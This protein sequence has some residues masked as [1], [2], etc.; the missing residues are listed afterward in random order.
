MIINCALLV[1]RSETHCSHAS[2]YALH[3]LTLGRTRCGRPQTTIWTISKNWRER[4]RA[5]SWRCHKI[6]R[7]G[8]NLWSRALTHNH[9]IINYRERENT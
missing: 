9:L 3:Q 6:E 4:E 2:M 8:V 7:P 5:N 1:A